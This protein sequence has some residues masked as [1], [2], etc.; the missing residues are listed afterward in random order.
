MMRAACASAVAE[1][2]RP[3]S[4]AGAARAAAGFTLVEVMVAL[5]V[6]AVALP[7][8]L[9]TL[10]QQIDG[11]AYLRDRSLAQLVAANKLSELRLRAAASGSVLRGRESGEVELA[12]R[13]WYWLLQGSDTEL[14]GLARVSVQ[15]GLA[16][17]GAQAR[18]AQS[19]LYTLN[20]FLGTGELPPLPG[21]GS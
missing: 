10:D 9:F 8:L 20:A 14:P 7:A 21:T 2:G 12:G 5:A 15:V 1:V 13:T 6:V 11:T 19:T 16:P 4:F 3:L 17:P 18:D